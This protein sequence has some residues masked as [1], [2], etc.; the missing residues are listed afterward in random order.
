MHL[1]KLKEDKKGSIF[2][3]FLMLVALF[4]L[5]LFIIIL[6]YVIP[7]VTEGLR[8]SALNDS[9]ASR[10]A[11][12]AADTVTERLD[13]IFLFIFVGLLM[14]MLITSFMIESHPIFI[15]IFIF[16]LAFAIIIGGIMGN[17]YEEFTENE[18]LNA[19]AQEQ[20]YVNAIMGNYVMVL[21]GVGILCMIIIFARARYGG[22]RI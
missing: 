4:G 5:A 13:P 15:P 19:T 18:L 16:L 11:L 20:T 7:E 17:V 22:Q 14:G 12:G 21:L 8:E 3:V 1:R 10:V 2:G 6:T 9:A